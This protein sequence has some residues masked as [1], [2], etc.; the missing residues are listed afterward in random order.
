MTILLRIIATL[1]LVAILIVV[2]VVFGFVWARQGWS[3]ASALL[4]PGSAGFLG[5]ALLSAP[6]IGL[7]A[8]AWLRDRR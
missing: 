1:W 5:T 8:F 7:L 2:T 6:G 4:D 3:A